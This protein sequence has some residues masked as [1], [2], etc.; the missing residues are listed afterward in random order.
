MPSSYTYVDFHC[1]TIGV[2]P[3]LYE[4]TCHLDLKRGRGFCGHVQVFAAWVEGKDSKEKAKNLISRFYEEQK[5]HENLLSLCKTYSGIETALKEKKTAAILSIEGGEA[6]EGNI[7]NLDYFYG[8]GVRL[9][10]LTW[11]HENEL[12]GG[13]MSGYTEGLKPFGKEVVQKMQDMDMIV[14]VSHLNENGFWDVIEISKK[15]ITASHSNSKKICGHPRNLTDEQFLAIK[16]TGGVVGINLYSQFLSPKGATIDDIVKHIEHFCSLGGENHVG[17]GADFDGVDELPKDIAGIEDVDKIFEYLL[18]LNYK[19]EVV[20][21]IA[22]E[23][24]LNFLKQT[25]KG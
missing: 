8:L 3:D 14:D 13:S 23:N 20:R 4:N 10:T 21:K 5:K 17:M 1:D 22:G 25:L 15:P 2:C 9:I 19:E 6:L 16:N 11:N 7:E 12:G 18:K 24:Y